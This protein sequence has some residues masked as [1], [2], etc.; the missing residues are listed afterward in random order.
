MRYVEEGSDP[1]VNKELHE[2]IDLFLDEFMNEEYKG[3]DHIVAREHYSKVFHDILPK[4]LR[5]S[6]LIVCKP[7]APTEVEEVV[8]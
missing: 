6:A 5:L 3:R 2:Q 7:K 1:V 8:K 4:Y